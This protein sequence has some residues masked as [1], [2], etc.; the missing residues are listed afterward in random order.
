VTDPAVDR[1]V[2]AA[3]IRNWWMMAARGGLAV[4]FGLS[5]LWWLD[6]TLPTIVVLLGFTPSSTGCWPS[7]PPRMAVCRPVARLT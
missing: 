7:L 1:S 3:M 2:L 5:V 4:L 6:V